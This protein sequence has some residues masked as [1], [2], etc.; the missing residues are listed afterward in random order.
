MSGIRIRVEPSD[1]GAPKQLPNELG[2]GRVFTSRMF[3]QRYA[4]GKGWHDAVIGP[5]R[6]LALDPAAEV[7]HC[8]QMIFDGTKAYRRPD[9]NLNLFRVQKNAERFNKS[10]SRMA[11]PQVDVGEHVEAIAELVRL[12]HAWT[13]PQEGA[14]LYIRP[15]MIATE[16]TLEVRASREFL[17]Y[18]ILSPVGPYFSG[19]FNPVSVYVSDQHV[20]TVRGGTGEAKTPGNYAGSL[21]GTEQ[22]LAAGYQ[23]V[24]WLDAV[25][26]RYVDEVGAMNIAFVYEG[27]HIRTPALSGAI[28]PGITRDSLLRLAPDLG[29]RATEDRIDI[30]EVLSDI[31]AGK[32]TEAFGIG[33]GAV[34]APVGCFG[35]QGR[36]YALGAGKPGPVAQSLF[37]GLTDIQYGR[38]P[39]PYGWT[40]LVKVAAAGRKTPIVSSA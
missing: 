3:T 13:P 6:P 37:K 33:T 15:V 9:G 40:Q 25:E 17:H 12:E 28:L 32:I 39:D 31:E 20:R 8:G 5:Y 18:I 1:D 23:Q 21:A 19:G 24:L 22:A 30:H 27:K 16:N 29:F 10:A 36:D 38:A 11:M 14:A 35:Y 2:F 7:F 34:I 26:R 4:S